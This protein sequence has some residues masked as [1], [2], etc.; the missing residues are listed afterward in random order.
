[1]DL[2][3][4]RKA[5]KMLIDLVLATDL[6]SHFDILAVWKRKE[7]IID[8]SKDEDK[9]LVMQ[10]ILKSGDLGHPSRVRH[11]HLTWS[12]LVTEEFFMQGD[13]EKKNGM[14]VS[15][16]MD[17][18]TCN[19]V[20]SQIGFISFLVQPIF[21]AFQAY[22]NTDMYAMLVRANL[23][24][25]E[26]L[27]LESE[28][29]RR[30]KE[31]EEEELRRL[32]QEREEL[33]AQKMSEQRQKLR[34]EQL[35]AEAFEN[36]IRTAA[37]K[38]AEKEQAAL[39]EE[40]Q[41]AVERAKGAEL[42]AAQ[43]LL[44]AELA[45]D[46]EADEAGQLSRSS[47]V[48]VRLRRENDNDWPMSDLS[49]ADSEEEVEEEAA[50]E[51]EEAER[52][53]RRDK[54]A[55]QSLAERQEERQRKR[56]ERSEHRKK[57]VEDEQLREVEGEREERE[58]EERRKREEE[59]RWTNSTE[60][61]EQEIDQRIQRQ[62]LILQ[63]RSRG[64]SRGVDEDGAEREVDP[65]AALAPLQR[66]V[67]AE[68]S[69]AA[70]QKVT[71]E[72][73]DA[74][75]YGMVPED[76][77]EVEV[78]VAAA[79]AAVSAPP[80][81]L[82]SPTPT[83]TSPSLSVRLQRSIELDRERV[84]A[85]RERARAK[86]VRE[87]SKL[88]SVEERAAVEEVAA[89]EERVRLLLREEQ[90]AARA[91]AE[92][93]EMEQLQAEAADASTHTAV[94]AEA[95]K[96]KRTAAVV[97][98]RERGR[99]EATR[100][101]SMLLMDKEWGKKKPVAEERR[102]WLAY[103]HFAEHHHGD[104][105]KE[106]RKEDAQP[107]TGTRAEA[108]APARAGARAAVP[109][110]TAEEWVDEAETQG[111]R[112]QGKAAGRSALSASA[113]GAS[114]LSGA[115]S[116]DELSR[117][118]R[119][120]GE[121]KAISGGSEVDSDAEPRFTSP[122]S[123]LRQR[124]GSQRRDARRRLS[125]VPEEVPRRLQQTVEGQAESEEEAGEGT[126]ARVEVEERESKDRAAARAR[127]GPSQRSGSRERRPSNAQQVE[128]RDS[129][130]ALAD[131]GQ[132][133]RLRPHVTFMEEKERATP[134][135][136]STRRPR[137]STVAAAQP[138]SWDEEDTESET[139]GEE[140]RVELEMQ[141]V[142]EEEKETLTPHSQPQPQLASIAEERQ[143]RLDKQ[144]AL[145]A[146]QRRADAEEADERRP[147]LPSAA[148]ASAPS[149]SPDPTSPSTSSTPIHAAFTSF[150][151]LALPHL[152]P[153]PVSSSAPLPISSPYSFSAPLELLLP[154]FTSSPFHSRSLVPSKPARGSGDAEGMVGD[155]GAELKGSDW[156]AAD[157]EEAMAAILRRVIPRSRQAEIERARRAIIAK[158]RV[159]P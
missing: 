104:Q 140:L 63:S 38:E 36:D 50:D 18:S 118:G 17:R 149:S 88:L 69:G 79:V 61:I 25:W 83:P 127:L 153:T 98:A 116:A 46:Q 84:E 85:Q 138:R 157:D 29:L 111:S 119:L 159:R 5:R 123:S 2:T 60:R 31:E 137:Q 68:S 7:S 93:A 90:A 124:G 20:T 9:L 33:E 115:D 67:E 42:T 129:K 39:E 74:P 51:A 86:A 16:M 80:P 87:R 125:R 156:R 117:R 103:L 27:N 6:A 134:V 56:R 28:E 147:S 120:S 8:L 108:A 158:H 107:K 110:V 82:A 100:E 72:A 70:T 52:Q 10:M 94:A 26:R 47:I 45:R 130:L 57:E 106:R 13:R 76:D 139:E 135:T 95:A 40:K 113:H 92:R 89:L 19:I 30:A 3:T 131:S 21:S 23:A 73:P 141:R 75:W 48:D 154:S 59:E 24:M 32:A 15:A 126:R 102:V 128:R 62:S 81:P 4:Y 58:R 77:A 133:R 150:P 144:R 148:P 71:A 99:S 136:P 142:G 53:R 44:E 78:E 151:P 152:L 121:G 55:R 146:Q 105:A 11:L 54:R 91:E 97:G 37:A 66:A 101:V 14:N 143:R 12:E 65:D 43:R 145:R 41:R 114:D 109:L 34:L 1:M 22:V 155:G 64:R 49:E 35:Q 122:F 96:R 112:A 132:R